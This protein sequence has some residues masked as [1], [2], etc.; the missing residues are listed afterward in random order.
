MKQ[1]IPTLE[2]VNQLG[3]LFQLLHHLSGAKQVLR[4]LDPFLQ[5][6]RMAEEPQ[7]AAPIPENG[8]GEFARIPAATSTPSG[9]VR[10]RPS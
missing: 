5:R 1:G 7:I 9:A 2:E 10:E 6:G 3:Q 8:W 4:L